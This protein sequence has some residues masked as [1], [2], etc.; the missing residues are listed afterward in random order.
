MAAA[1]GKAARRASEAHH[2]QQYSGECR[3]SGFRSE[4]GDLDQAEDHR[5]GGAYA[6]QRRE[7]LLG[8]RPEHRPGGVCNADPA[9]QRARAQEQERPDKPERRRG[10][11]CGRRRR[12]G[13]EQRD[14]KRAE[15]EHQLDQHRVEGQGD[16]EERVVLESLSE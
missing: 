6:E 11:N 9:R 8:Q 7:S 4:G 13:D 12:P 1:V 3:P 10:E 16:H 15:N 2:T 5:V 14:E